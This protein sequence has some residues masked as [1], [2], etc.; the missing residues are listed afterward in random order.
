MLA[1]VAAAAAGLVIGTCAKMALPLFT[2]PVGLAPLV[3]LATFAAIG[4]AAL[5][6]A[7]GCSPCWC[8]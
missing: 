2:R 5:A 3:A 6:A 1:G 8:R 7:T 4:V